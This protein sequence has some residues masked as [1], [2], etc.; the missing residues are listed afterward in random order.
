MSESQE[1]GSVCKRFYNKRLMFFSKN[2]VKTCY[3]KGLRQKVVI[4]HQNAETTLF[5]SKTN[6]NFECIK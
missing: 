5:S 1:L 2:E 6:C 3:K 4:L